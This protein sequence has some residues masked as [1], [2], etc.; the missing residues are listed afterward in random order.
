MLFISYRARSCNGWE[1][2]FTTPPLEVA[3]L[4]LALKV[5]VTSSSSHL[6]DKML[7][8]STGIVDLCVSHSVHY[9]YLLLNRYYNSSLELLSS[10]QIIK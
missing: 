7:A 4:H 9:S 2:V 8:A 5:N 1:L 3:P 10:T 6:G